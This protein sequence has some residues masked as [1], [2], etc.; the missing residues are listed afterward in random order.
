MTSFID[1]TNTRASERGQ[2]TAVDFLGV[3]L[4]PKAF[5]RLAGKFAAFRAAQA[6]RSKISRELNMYSDRDLLE[7]GLS[8]GDIPAVASGTYRR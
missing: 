5:S 3:S 7:L 1:D 6:E 2:S 8:R 4:A